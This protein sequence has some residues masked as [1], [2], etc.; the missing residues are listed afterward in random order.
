[1]ESRSYDKPV[2]IIGGGPIGL[3][4]AIGMK[5]LNPALKVIVLEQYPIYQRRHT[6][7]M[8]HAMLSEYMHAVEGKQQ[9]LL[10]QLLAKLKNDR[11]IR[12]SE[13][14]ETYFKA[15]AQQLGVEIQIETVKEETIKERLSSFNPCLIIG[16]DG[17]HSIVS[18]TLFPKDNQVKHEFDYALQLR[19]EIKGTE[20]ADPLPKTQFLANMSNRGVIANEY[21]G[22]YDEVKKVTPVTTQVIITKEEFETL[23]DKAKSKNPIKPIAKRPI[24]RCSQLP[25]EPVDPNQDTWTIIMGDRL[26]Q[27]NKNRDNYEC[28]LEAKEIDD[29]ELTHIL[30]ETAEEKSDVI[31]IALDLDQKTKLDAL[32]KKKDGRSL[33]SNYELIPEAPKSFI[34]EYLADQMHSG[35]EIVSDSVTI[36]VNELPAT[37]AK[38]VF[39]ELNGIPV[40]LVGDSGLGLSL[41]KGF[42]AGLKSTAEFFLRLKASIKRGFTDPQ[43]T[44]KALSQYQDWFLKIFAPQKIKQASAA[45]QKYINFPRALMMSSSVIKGSTVSVYNHYELGLIREALLAKGKDAVSTDLQNDRFN[46]YPHRPYAPARLVQWDITPFGYSFKKIKKIAVDYF[47]PYKSKQHLAQDLKQPL[48][49]FR[50]IINGIIKIP[51]GLLFLD[52]KLTGDGFITLIRGTLEL[53]MAPLTCLV[54]PLTRGFMNLV[55]P[56]LMIENNKGIKKLS[57]EIMENLNAFNAYTPEEIYKLTTRCYDI[58][59]K[60]SKQRDRGQRTQVELDEISCFNYLRD[61]EATHDKLTA[62]TRYATL[63]CPKGGKPK[64]DTGRNIKLCKM[65]GKEALFIPHRLR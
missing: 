58:H 53:A 40:V 29:A 12:T 27:L 63:F 19:Y 25:K 10:S 24:Y 65:T 2:V 52:K 15:L 55:K 21:M 35:A 22:A 23:K 5:L 13:L 42:N 20:K 48:I 30:F 41:F 50:N 1:M 54:K 61:A 14:E 49:G 31:E 26:F 17:T 39:T 33:Y 44:T 11:H 4:H 6:L 47:K 57:D 51:V 56:P 45:S 43:E 36:S 38:Q 18:R 37:H 46:F 28:I 16:A 59:R 64:D 9:A 34:T 7:N 3:A 8:M 62:I 60:F 32:I